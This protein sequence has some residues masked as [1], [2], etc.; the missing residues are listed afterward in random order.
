VSKEFIIYKKDGNFSNIKL[1]KEH[2]YN[3]P[4]GRYLTKI[5]SVKKRSLP[6]NKFYWSVCVELV[7]EGLRSAG[8]DAVRNKDDA[9][10]IMKSLFLKIKEEKNGI[11]IERVRSTTEL[12]TVE[13]ME[14]LQHISTWAFDYLSVT[15]PEPNQQ[16]E[17]SLDK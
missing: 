1:W 2:L 14:Y 11:K 15:I 5:E 12:K 3:L 13:F 10:E 6:Q 16:M 9:H 17:M 4:D 8:F 7:Y